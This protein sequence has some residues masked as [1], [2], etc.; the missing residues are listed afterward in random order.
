VLLTCVRIG[1]VAALIIGA[2]VDIGMF[3]AFVDA[4]VDIGSSL[5]ALAYWCKGERTAASFV[6]VAGHGS[7][8]VVL[9]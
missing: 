9:E 7:S 1:I 2:V 3:I 4:S 5:V 6:V 8:L